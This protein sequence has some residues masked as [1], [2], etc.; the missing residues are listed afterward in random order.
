MSNESDL[1]YSVRSSTVVLSCRCNVLN[2]QSKLYVLRYTVSKIKQ[3][4]SN[5]P[6]KV[7]MSMCKIQ[8]FF[9]PDPRHTMICRFR[10]CKKTKE[11]EKEEGEKQ[12]W[13][14]FPKEN[15]FRLSKQRDR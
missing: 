12:V 7:V 9:L 5:P 14:G 4:L 3:K 6:G 15:L 13:E 1:V 2:K 8:S 11:N 10:T